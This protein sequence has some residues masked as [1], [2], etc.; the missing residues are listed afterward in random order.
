M[1]QL[2]TAEWAADDSVAVLDLTIGGL[3]RETASR[4]PDAIALVEGAPEPIERRRWTYAELLAESERAA[5]ALLGRFAPGDRIAV[6]AN[7]IPEWVFLE[8][9]AGL[10]GITLVTVNPALRKEE[11]AYVLRHSRSDGI[12]YVPEY[13]GSRM[14]EMLE[15]IEGELPALRAKV[16]FTDW[17]AFCASGSPDQ[18][19][20]DV[21]VGAA[22][23]ILY[24]SG[25]TGRP[26]GAVLHHRGVVN[27]ARVNVDRLGAEPGMVQ[28]ATMPLF[29]I[30]GCGLTVL[31]TIASVGTLVL[32]PYFDPALLFRLIE[33]ERSAW[34]FGAPTMLIACLEHPRLCD[35][36]VSSVR[37]IVAVGAPVLPALA[38]RVEGAFDARL[39][40]GFGQTET[41]GCITLIG[42]W[43]QPEDRFNT[44]GTP[45][46]QTDVKV[47]DVNT[48]ETV[49]PDVEGELC[50]RGYFVMTGYFDNP[51]A[52][53]AAIDAD[54]WLHTGDLAA[55]DSRGFCR[56]TGR[57]KD[58]IIRGGEN[59]FPREIEQVLFEHEDVADVAVVGVPDPTWGEQ[60]VAFIR[61]A[62]GRSPD[63]D[64][65]RRYCHEHLAAH[66][67][68]LHWVIVDE[69]PKT[70]SG[71]VQKFVL[72]DQFV[73]M[74]HSRRTN[75][76]DELDALRDLRSGGA[77]QP[78]EEVVRRVVGVTLGY[79]PTDLRGDARFIDIGGDSLSALRFSRLVEEVLDT[80]VP[81]GVVIDP[82][83]DLDRLTNYIEKKRATDDDRPTAATIHGGDST[84]VRA[85]DLTLDKF[86]DA[87]TLAEAKTLAHPGD[88]AQTVLLSGATGYLGRFLCLEWLQRL[89]K[90]GGTL[91]CL[92]RARD[93]DAARRRLSAAFDR[94]DFDL[95]REFQKAADHLE[96]VVGDIDEPNLG[97]DDSTWNRLANTVDLI[98]H[99]AALVN[100]ALPYSQM[101]GPNV[102][103]TA[104]IIRL[105]LTSKLKR[106]NYLSTVA[107]A[108]LTDGVIGEDVDIR[109]ANTVREIDDTYANGYAN[110]K[111]AGEVLMRE[112]HDLCSLPVGV[113][114][115]DMIL[116]HSRY[117]GQLNVPDLF[118]RL[119]L[120]IVATGIAPYSFYAR[121]GQGH[122]M[123]AHYDGLPVDFVAEAIATLGARITEGFHTYNV[124]NPHDDGVSLDLCVDWLIDAGHAIQR[125]DDYGDWL[126]RFESAMR[127]LPDKQRRHSELDLLEA[128]K[129]P[130]QA[131][132]GPSLPAG[133]F[134]DGVRAAQIGAERDIPHI[135][136]ALICEYI[137]DLRQLELL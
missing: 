69:F 128:F 84:E 75:L 11:L 97:L 73:A 51:E 6:W 136:A 98:V 34:F 77:D 101:F 86:I 60:V 96:V 107:V 21:D 104:E 63:P 92:T 114:R 30:V 7:N 116:A 2:S 76:D 119:M 79:R 78:V 9:A 110:S 15:A 62:D 13:Q 70:T 59:I 72:R 32:L 127:A 82:T 50:T 54:G 35:I 19:L 25:T 89:A 4:A 47:I 121:D 40:I 39:C 130:A 135:S 10:A 8:L 3:L 83:N 52:T 22:A 134:R 43:D 37:F 58:M 103:G 65:L 131:L 31:G 106:I 74:A 125:I 1:V 85:G 93:A 14:A 56:I 117:A 129:P 102:V 68:P 111:W 87:K 41:S 137:T 90:S 124:V 115:C 45:V 100:H 67:A 112:A 24:T 133:S 53:A 123:R 122:R 55:I 81:V 113:F 120:S 99:P 105:A 80:E 46:A 33:E 71:K 23:Q 95:T 18:L 26:K 28:I 38:S 57:L 42:P 66:K 108:T 27:S 12:F 16:S 94:G 36:D 29:H 61:P 44:L 17:D 132:S 20:P 91:I 126:T 109:I 88:A 48:G 118:T 64:R 49:A 5:R